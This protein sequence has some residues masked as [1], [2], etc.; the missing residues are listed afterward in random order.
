VAGRPKCARD[1][2]RND[3][4]GPPDPVER[5][6]GLLVL[7]TLRRVAF[8]CMPTEDLVCF[9]N[10]RQGVYRGLLAGLCPRFCKS[11]HFN[12]KNNMNR[13]LLISAVL[14]S[15][16][17]LANFGS[18]SDASTMPSSAALVAAPQM[19]DIDP[20]PRCQKTVTTA[21]TSCAESGTNDI[22]CKLGFDYQSCISSSLTCS[23]GARCDQ[24]SGVGSCN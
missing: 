4:P 16:G 5:D 24:D 19:G 15:C 23:N 8:P 7:E 21:C 6:R 3:P 13:A 22:E 11:L 18:K 17:F 9:T 12:S 20:V 1:P 14:V 10:F 2:L